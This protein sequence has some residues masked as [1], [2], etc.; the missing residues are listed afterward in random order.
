MIKLEDRPDTTPAMKPKKRIAPKLDITYGIAPTM[1]PP[2]I[3]PMIIPS[4]WGL[5][6]PVRIEIA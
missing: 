3:V 4:I 2:L 1:I 6:L 5:P